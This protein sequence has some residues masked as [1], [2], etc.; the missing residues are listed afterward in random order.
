MFQTQETLIRGHNYL[1]RFNSHNLL[2]LQWIAIFPR[3]VYFYFHRNYRRNVK[4]IESQPNSRQFKKALDVFFYVL[5][6]RAI[7]ARIRAWEE[8]NSVLH[9]FMHPEY[10]RIIF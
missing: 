7:L 6:A 3:L 9:H 8:G 2:N 5:K 4:N 1:L 10:D